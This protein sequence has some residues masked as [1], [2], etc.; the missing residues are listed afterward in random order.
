MLPQG[1][2]SVP[3]VGTS[4]ARAWLP[5]SPLLGRSDMAC[6]LATGRPAALLA[7]SPEDNVTQA[8]ALLTSSCNFFPAGGDVCSSV[9]M[10]KPPFLSN[11]KRTKT[12]AFVVLAGLR[13]AWF[14]TLVVFQPVDTSVPSSRWNF[15]AAG[16]RNKSF[17]KGNGFVE[18]LC[19]SPS[20]VLTQWQCNGMPL[21]HNIQCTHDA[22][23]LLC[24]PR[25]LG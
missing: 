1:I 7:A 13:M 3:R 10:N 12:V 20:P 9:Q 15:T 21:Y 8:P 2:F 24:L 6:Q 11:K 14:D 25:I 16:F 22:A 18:S 17:C 5:A 23:T 4:V 19:L